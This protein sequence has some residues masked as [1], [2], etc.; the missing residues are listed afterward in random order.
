VIPT[1]SAQCRRGIV[2]DKRRRDFRFPAGF[3]ES[4]GDFSLP[5]IRTLLGT[6][7]T[8]RRWRTSFTFAGREHP[9]AT[10]QLGTIDRME[11]VMAEGFEAGDAEEFTKRAN[12]PV[13]EPS[14]SGKR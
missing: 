4:L 7:S 3:R 11:N 2:R 12:P 13:N 10:E 9:R 5:T 8:G 6:E 1:K 14:Q